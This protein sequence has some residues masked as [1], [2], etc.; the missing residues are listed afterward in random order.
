M[1]LGMIGLGRMGANMV[2][3]LASAGHDCVVFDAAPEAVVALAGKKISGTQ[4]LEALATKLAPPRIVWLMVPAAAVDET[5]AQLTPHLASG[6][7]VV[8]GGNTH[9]VD[10]LR[11][12]RLLAPEGIHHV[13]VGTSGGVWGRER[14]YCLTIG[15]ESSIVTHLDPI[16][17]SLAPGTSPARRGANDAPARPSAGTCTAAITAPGTS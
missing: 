14:G 6:D 8:D 15:G 12:A 10:D 9:Y 16:F 7:I 11:R 2:Q 4:S 13:D 17:L 5:L 3:R 1:Q